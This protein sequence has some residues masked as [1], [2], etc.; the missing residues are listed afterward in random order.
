ERAAPRSERG[1]AP[2]RARPHV[3]RLARADP[4][5][6]WYRRDECGLCRGL[7]ERGGELFRRREPPCRILLE[8]PEDN[9]L[10][11]ERGIWAVRAPGRWRAVEDWRAELHQRVGLE[12]QFAGDELVEH[13]AE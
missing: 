12:R 2:G 5:T 8:A 10:D 13:D 4:V 9:R 11:R 7:L 6:A 1:A 3:H